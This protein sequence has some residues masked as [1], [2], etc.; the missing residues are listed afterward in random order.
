MTILDSIVPLACFGLGKINNPNL[1]DA[2]EKTY[3]TEITSSLPCHRLF[4]SIEFLKLRQ[5]CKNE[6]KDHT[7]KPPPYIL[8]VVVIV[9]VQLSDSKIWC[10]QFK[11][12]FIHWIDAAAGDSSNIWEGKESIIGRYTKTHPHRV[13]SVSWIYRHP[14]SRLPVPSRF[15]WPTDDGVPTDPRSTQ[16]PTFDWNQKELVTFCVSSTAQS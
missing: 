9:S 13:E 2:L 16:P 8:V 15:R 7:S 3:S 5:L 6:T 1:F 4:H 11:Q 14:P 12:L 10:V